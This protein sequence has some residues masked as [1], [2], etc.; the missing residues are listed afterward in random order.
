LYKVS[1]TQQQLA[2]VVL[3]TVN[4]LQAKGS[5]VRLVVPSDPEV[6]NE[7]GQ[8]LGVGDE[9]ILSA[10]EY[11][12]GHGYVAPVD[13]GLTRGTHTIT[14]AGMGWLEERGLLQRPGVSREEPRPDREGAREPSERPW[15]RRVCW[16][17]R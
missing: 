10:E 17:D 6:A 12:L 4:R 11:L 1:E 16:E 9:E 5:T 2:W 14:P 3:R 7:L 15:W 8:E 13:I